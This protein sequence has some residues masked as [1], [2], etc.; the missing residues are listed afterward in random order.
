MKEKTFWPN[1]FDAFE[2]EEEFSFS[3]LRRKIFLAGK[4]RGRRKMS[5]E[6]S[7]DKD[8]IILDEVEDEE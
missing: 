6:L 5:E 8:E 7:E 1:F 2:Q 4:I 3:K